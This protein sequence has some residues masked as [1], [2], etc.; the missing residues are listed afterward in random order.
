MLQGKTEFNLSG[1]TGS[2]RCLLCGLSGRGLHHSQVCRPWSLLKDKEQFIRSLAEEVKGHFLVN[3]LRPAYQALR[4]LNSKPS[5]QV[6]AVRL[7]GGQIVSDPVVVR[8]RWAEYFEQLYQVDPPTVNLDVGSAMILLPDPSITEDPLSL[9]EVGE[10]I[11]K[12][13]SGKVLARILLSRIRDHLLRH[14]RP[15]QSGFTPGKST[16]DCILALLVIVE[17][18]HEFGRGLLAAYID[19]KK[20]IDTVH[21]KKL[22]DILRLRGIP[23]RIIELIVDLY[24]GTESA[25]KIQ[26]FGDLLAARTLKSQRALHNLVVQFITLGYQTRK[27]ADGL[28]WQQGS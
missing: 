27:S 18:R 9:T 21:W 22:W 16:I 3:D 10:A 13:K 5:S 26:D 2:H 12:L 11:S 4:K 19:L 28:S 23:T 20:G 17:R 6:I 15:E 7:A 14:Q 25:T 24:I 1:D 8:G